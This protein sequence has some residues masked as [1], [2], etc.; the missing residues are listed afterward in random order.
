VEEQS[1]PQ[2]A[3]MESPWDTRSA[4]INQALLGAPELIGTLAIAR[5][6]P[7]KLLLF[8]PAAIG[9]VTAWRRFVCG[10]CQYYGETCS[11]MLGIMTARMMPPDESKP[12]DRNVMILDFTFLGTLWLLPLPQVFKKK[13]L[14]LLYAASVAAC[15]GAVMTNACGRCGNDFCPMKDVYEAVLG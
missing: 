13:W 1:E 11:T 6:K 7:R 5:Y 4:M 10:R 14:G 9:F 8:L 2:Q 12:L 15:L 3:S